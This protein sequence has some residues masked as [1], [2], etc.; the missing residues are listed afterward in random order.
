MSPASRPAAGS[1]VLGLL[2]ATLVATGC[3]REDRAAADPTRGPRDAEP[4]SRS[5]DV[6]GSPSEVAAVAGGVWVT[7]PERRS[8]WREGA[9][10]VP[11][12]GEPLDLVET[13]F[14]VWVA[15]GDGVGGSLVRV[16]A[17][18]G[19]IRQ[20]VSLTSDDTAPTR[21]SYDGQ[22]LWVL[23]AARASVVVVDPATG[24]VDR[25]IM[26]DA[27]TQEVASGGAGTFTTG[28]AELPLAYLADDR[29]GIYR[30]ASEV[31]TLPDELAVSID[32]VWVACTDAGRVVAVDPGADSPA[33]IADLERPDDVVLTSRGTVVALS[34]GPTL[35]LLDPA[36]GTERARLRLGDDPAPVSGG[37]ELA[38]V[39]VD[40]VVLHPGTE[41]LYR[42]PLTDLER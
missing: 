9:A 31:C 19:E 28:Q 22:R 34:E 29:E 23:D 10:S 40:V 11:V 8:L 15:L 3:A 20:R 5:V 42:V 36:D 32:V 26:V 13:P 1:V 21:L 17:S 30:V 18:T 33:A 35:V 38:E 37:V 4:R 12:P 25:R 6:Q 24:R 7:Q 27:R 14:G 41:R 39:G 2:A 16:D